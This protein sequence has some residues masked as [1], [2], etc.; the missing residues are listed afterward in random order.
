MAG[1]L[2]DKVIHLTVLFCLSF[3][4]FISHINETR[5]DNMLMNDN[6]KNHEYNDL[7]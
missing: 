3:H 7:S 1:K 4:L 6:G 2:I 5:D